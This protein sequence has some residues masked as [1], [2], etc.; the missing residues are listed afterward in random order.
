LGLGDEEYIWVNTSQFCGYKIR[1]L[2]RNFKKDQLDIRE[3]CAI[4]NSTFWRKV[5]NKL[6]SL[7]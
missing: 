6:R 7:F 3:G 1:I 2:A 5:G 4:P